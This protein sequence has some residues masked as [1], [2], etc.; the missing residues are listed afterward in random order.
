MQ[1][2]ALRNQ[3]TV[4]DITNHIVKVEREYETLITFYACKNMTI[5]EDD[6]LNGTYLISIDDATLNNVIRIEVINGNGQYPYIM[7]YV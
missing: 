1:V 5:N 6:K 7:L 2:K 3:T 4:Y